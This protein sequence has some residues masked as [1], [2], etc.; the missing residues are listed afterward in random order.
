MAT[1]T[2]TFSDGQQFNASLNISSSFISGFGEVEFV[3]D[4]EY[5]TG[6]YEAT[7]SESEQVFETEG[8]V[9]SENFVVHAIPSNYGLITWN[10]SALTV[11]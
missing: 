7:P 8:K 3:H 4:G 1:F 5:Y 6:A 10:G 9:M 2:A 11:S